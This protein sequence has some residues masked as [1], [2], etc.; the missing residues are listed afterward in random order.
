MSPPN[1][2]AQPTG[3]DDAAVWQ[4]QPRS[5]SVIAAQAKLEAG[6]PA[7]ALKLLATADQ[8]QLDELERARLERL[9]AQLAFASIRGNEA[10][11]LLLDAAKRLE[12]LDAE[13]ARETYL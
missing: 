7:A 12:P 5:S 2:S 9:R 3:P 11:P 1:S 8:G 6:A 10:P 13:L 4:L